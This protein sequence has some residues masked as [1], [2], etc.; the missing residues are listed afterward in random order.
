M[1]TTSKEAARCSGGATAKGFPGDDGGRH[2]RRGKDTAKK[3]LRRP[4][5]PAQRGVFWQ[6]VVNMR[7][8]RAAGGVP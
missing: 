8:A 2:V 4:L 5:T 1:N 6:S 3:T 7:A